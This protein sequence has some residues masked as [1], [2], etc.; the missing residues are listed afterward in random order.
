MWQLFP[1]EELVTVLNHDFPVLAVSLIGEKILVSGGD[2]CFLV[3]WMW[4]DKH[5]LHTLLSHTNSLSFIVQENNEVITGGGDGHIKIYSTE[6]LLKEERTPA[7]EPHLDLEVSTEALQ[8]YG[9]CGDLLIISDIENNVFVVRVT[10]HTPTKVDI[11]IP[12]HERLK[13]VVLFSPELML[14]VDA[15]VKLWQLEPSAA[16]SLH[17][18]SNHLELILE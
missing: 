14:S 4:E 9:H 7:V 8:H 18:T 13:G 6:D 1:A 3:V 10:D 11:G 2:D 5:K 12:Y 16:S 17:R 15:N